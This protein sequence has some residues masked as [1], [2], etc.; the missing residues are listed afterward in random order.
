[1]DALNVINK[2]PSWQAVK[3]AITKA[4]RSSARTSIAGTLVA[5]SKWKVA[6]EASAKLTMYVNDNAVSQVQTKWC[7]HFP[8]LEQKEGAALI[9]LSKDIR[10][11]ELII[12]SRAEQF[13]SVTIALTDFIYVI[14]IKNE[15]TLQSLMEEVSRK[16]IK[17]DR[18]RKHL[19]YSLEYFLHWQ[20]D[21]AHFI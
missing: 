12:S 1:M 8:L 13:S 2:T 9:S 20:T 21:Y 15:I 3:L 16:W 10:D 11:W 17:L 5:E 4:L 18:E 14:F 7:V 6:D 19:D